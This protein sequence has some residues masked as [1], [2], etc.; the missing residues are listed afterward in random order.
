MFEDRFST[1]ES[2]TVDDTPPSH[3][4][5]LCLENTM[6]F[7]PTDAT[8]DMPVHLQGD[9][10]TSTERDLKQRDLQ[11]QERVRRILHPTAPASTPRTAT[12]TPRCQLTRLPHLLKQFDHLLSP[13]RQEM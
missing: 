6:L 9:W 12:V 11:R 13:I 4:E 1:V 2:L 7:V 3:W 8:S 10:L 5:E